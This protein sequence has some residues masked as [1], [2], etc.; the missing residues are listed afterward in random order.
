[1]SRVGRRGDSQFPVDP[2]ASRGAVGE[3]ERGSA[4]A[5]TG[6]DPSRAQR[7]DSSVFGIRTI[8]TE[9]PRRVARAATSL[10]R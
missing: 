3:A 8:V 7:A 10:Y 5:A 2:H 9:A 1:M 4:S 6:G